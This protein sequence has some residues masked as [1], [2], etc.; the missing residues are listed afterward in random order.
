MAEGL[1]KHICTNE[2][3]INSGGSFATT[4]VR[5]EAIR[6]LGEM[7][8]DISQNLSKSVDEFTGEQIDIVLTVCDNAKETCPY[9]PATTALVHHSF[10]DPASAEGSE[11]ERLNVFREVRDQIKEYLINEFLPEFDMK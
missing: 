7:G 1:L 9:F 11:E 2:Y 10:N 5:P 3:K 6:V 4:N 8:I